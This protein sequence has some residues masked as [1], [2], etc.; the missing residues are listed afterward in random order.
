MPNILGPNVL[1]I[2]SSSIISI[3]DGKDTAILFTLILGVAEFAAGFITWRIIPF[4]GRY[5][6]N[7]PKFKIST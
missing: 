3:N 7:N 5:T 2:L 1:N 4:Y 6:K